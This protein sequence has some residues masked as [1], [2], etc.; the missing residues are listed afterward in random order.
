VSQR[1]E[2]AIKS[3]DG[4][5]APCDAELN[6]WFDRITAAG[7]GQPLTV[8]AF[9]EYGDAHTITGT[10]WHVLHMALM[11][12]DARLR[13]GGCYRD[14]ADEIYALLAGGPMHADGIQELRQ[15]FRLGAQRPWLAP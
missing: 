4:T 9:D 14:R 6:T 1:H 10:A 12:M 8:V 15:V 3:A 11:A 2:Y 7:G 13:P 5:W